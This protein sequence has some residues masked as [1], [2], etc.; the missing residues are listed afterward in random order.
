MQESLLFH[1]NSSPRKRFLYENDLWN[2]SNNWLA[3]RCSILKQSCYLITELNQLL[4]ENSSLHSESVTPAGLSTRVPPIAMQRLGIP[5][6]CRLKCESYLCDNNHFTLVVLCIPLDF[7]TLFIW[8]PKEH[9]SHNHVRILEFRK[10]VS[11]GRFPLLSSSYQ[12]LALRPR[13][14]IRRMSNE[15]QGMIPTMRKE[16]ML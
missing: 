3:L 13:I 12:N 6:S 10:P 11:F 1:T 16:D 14:D 4:A 5:H 9:L 15:T 7:F 8:R 2:R